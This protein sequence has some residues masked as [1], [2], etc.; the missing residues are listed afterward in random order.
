MKQQPTKSASQ[1]MFN[2]FCTEVLLDTCISI[3]TNSQ[4]QY[5]SARAIGEQY[6]SGCADLFQLLFIQWQRG[7]RT[8]EGKTYRSIWRIDA[9]RA[10]LFQNILREHKKM[11]LT[12]REVIKLMGDLK[13]QKRV[14][15][16]SDDLSS[17]EAGIFSGAELKE[18]MDLKRALRK[19][20]SEEFKIR[21]S[22]M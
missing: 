6:S 18:V 8:L 14:K 13:P 2:I 15:I 9:E 17:Y 21:N 20:W 7:G 1:E 3:L 16:Y 12:A 5:G 11:P 22:K 4:F 19:E 10:K